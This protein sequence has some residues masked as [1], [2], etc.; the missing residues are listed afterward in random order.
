MR[1]D[2]SYNF[3]LKWWF[4]LDYQSFIRYEFN[5]T[6]AYSLHSQSSKIVIKLQS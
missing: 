1:Y 6:L 2:N 4:L 5:P 3:F